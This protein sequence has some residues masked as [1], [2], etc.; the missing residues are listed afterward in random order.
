MYYL[1]KV[2]I[3]KNR[4]RFDWTANDDRESAKNFYQKLSA[5]IIEKKVLS[6]KW[7]QAQGTGI[8]QQNGLNQAKKPHFGA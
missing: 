3:N 2:A 7:R 5:S 4:S 1:A 6:P 8:Q